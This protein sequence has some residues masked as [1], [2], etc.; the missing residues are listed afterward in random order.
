MSNPFKDDEQD[1]INTAAML[2]FQRAELL[3]L[4]AVFLEFLKKQNVS[5]GGMPAKDAMLKAR[6]VYLKAV[7]AKL[8]DD[9]PNQATR[10]TEIV[11][12]LKNFVP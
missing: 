11:E 8:S 1:A 7:L 12:D 2:A 5:V 6:D 4:K 9:Y 3:A 10:I